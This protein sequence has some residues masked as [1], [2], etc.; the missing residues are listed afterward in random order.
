M[1]LVVED[2]SKEKEPIKKEV[3]D[4]KEKCWL[5]YTFMQSRTLKLSRLSPLEEVINQSS[6]E[7][8]KRTN[9]HKHSSKHIHKYPH[10][11][12]LQALYLKYPYKERHLY[13]IC[14]SREKHSLI[15]LI[16]QIY[17]WKGQDY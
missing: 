8:S 14:F 5:L 10:A 16:F 11:D 15:K 17:Q 13:R 7:C 12:L 1:L 3:N 4:L 2:I 6:R 9:I